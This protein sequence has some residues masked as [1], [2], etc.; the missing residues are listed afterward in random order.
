LWQNRLSVFRVTTEAQVAAVDPFRTMQ[1]AMEETRLAIE[2]AR[3]EGYETGY[4]DALKRLNEFL[5]SQGGSSSKQPPPEPPGRYRGQQGQFASSTSA[6]VTR[7][8]VSEALE[9][10]VPRAAGAAEL[11]RIIDREHGVKLAATSVRRALAHLAQDGVASRSPGTKSWAFSRAGQQR[12]QRQQ[13]KTPGG[14]APGVPT[15]NG[16]LPLDA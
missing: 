16:A 6:G 2:D 11:I 9:M 15:S 5:A 13:R 10:L 14:D 7:Q 1:N 8:L 4:S 3:R 12:Q